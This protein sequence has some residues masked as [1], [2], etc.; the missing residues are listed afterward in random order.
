V[1]HMW[2][3]INV[4]QESHTSLINN[5]IHSNILSHCPHTHTTHNAL[6]SLIRTLFSFTYSNLAEGH[7]KYM[8]VCVCVFT[9]TTSTFIIEHVL[10]GRQVALTVAASAHWP[11]FCKFYNYLRLY[12]CSSVTHQPDELLYFKQHKKKH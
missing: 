7:V 11:P 9:I 10:A 5:I 8:Q 12:C 4:F 2:F 1:D 3:A 6:P